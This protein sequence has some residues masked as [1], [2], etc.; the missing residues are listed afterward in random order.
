MEVVGI[1]NSGLDEYDRKF[2]MT[3]IR[4]LQDV[5]GWQSNQVGGIEV[6]VDNLEDLDFVSDYIYY[7]HLPPSI[8]SQTIREKFSSIFFF[9][10][11]S[12]TASLISELLLP[13][14]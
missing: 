7:D 14:S 2:A 11:R 10:P 3:D 4:K 9:I 8:Y 13:Y 5:M 1:Y 6:F 12:I